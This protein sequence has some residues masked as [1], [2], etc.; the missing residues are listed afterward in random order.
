MVCIFGIILDK[1]LIKTRKTMGLFV[2][3]KLGGLYIL[4]EW[5]K[6]KKNDISYMSLNFQ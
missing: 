6:W 4:F 3:C 2:T 1:A 5:W